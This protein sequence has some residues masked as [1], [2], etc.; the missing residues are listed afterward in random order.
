MNDAISSYE[1]TMKSY[2]KGES[3]YEN[4]VAARQDLINNIQSSSED[5][6]PEVISKILAGD[7]TGAT[8]QIYEDRSRE[9]GNNLSQF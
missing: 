7:T 8:K 5:Y 9:I 4:T 6:S 1:S 3:S 2:Q